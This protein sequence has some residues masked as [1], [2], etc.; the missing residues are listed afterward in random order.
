MKHKDLFIYY[1]TPGVLGS[2]IGILTCQI[3]INKIIGAL[4]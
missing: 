1:I 4:N 2:T 3:I